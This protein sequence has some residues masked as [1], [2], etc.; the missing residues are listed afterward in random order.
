MVELSE[1]KIRRDVKKKMFRGKEKFLWSDEKPFPKMTL[2]DR[3]PFES[4]I[5]WLMI[6]GIVFS[7]IYVSAKRIMTLREK[8][9]C[10]DNSADGLVNFQDLTKYCTNCVTDENNYSS[11]SFSSFSDNMLELNLGN[12]TEPLLISDD[13]SSPMLLLSPSSSSSSSSV[14]DSSESIRLQSNLELVSSQ[15]A[16]TS[17]DPNYDP[18]SGPTEISTPAS[19][20]SQPGDPS[21]GSDSSDPCE[22]VDFLGSLN[23]NSSDASFHKTLLCADGQSDNINRNI[24]NWQKDK[25]LLFRGLDGN[26]WSHNGKFFFPLQKMWKGSVE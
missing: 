25:D 10:V 6:I 19:A 4:G 7:T 1:N 3:D 5:V 23:P 21:D 11:S 13:K 22:I 14:G 26:L 16:S 18:L 17:D 12:K 9:N 24:F 20:A 8:K 2:G 15:S